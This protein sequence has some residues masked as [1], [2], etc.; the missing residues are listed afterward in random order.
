MKRLALVLVT[1]ATILGV[2]APVF[3]NA[4]PVKT[5]VVKKVVKL[6]PSYRAIYCYD[7]GSYWATQKA[8]YPIYYAAN[9]ARYEALYGA[10][11]IYCPAL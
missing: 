5:T 10:N 6:S 9:N 3:V 4:V 1:I 8:A 2:S 11:T 7:G